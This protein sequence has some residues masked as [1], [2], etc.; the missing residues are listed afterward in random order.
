M[1]E[2]KTGERISLLGP[3]GHGFTYHE[4]KRALLVGGGIGIYPLLSIGKKYG[5]DAK[6]LFGFRNVSLINSTEL[7]ESHDIPVSVI[8]DDG[9]TDEKALSPSLSAR[10]LKRSR[11]TSSMSAVRGE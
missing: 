5:K 7:F 8:T 1:S 9:R 6:A 3:L 11:R 2:R 4:G 10:S